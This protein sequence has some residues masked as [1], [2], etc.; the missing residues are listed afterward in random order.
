MRA[1]TQGGNH[2]AGGAQYIKNDTDRACKVRGLDCF[3]FVRCEK[4]FQ[5]LKLHE[6][7]AR[8]G[9]VSI[10]QAAAERDRT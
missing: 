4:D 5:G 9:E 1:M 3:I 8:A 2:A 10:V 7:G 6:I